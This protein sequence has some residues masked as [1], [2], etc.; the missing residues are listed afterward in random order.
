MRKQSYLASTRI[1]S[2]LGLCADLLDRG[3]FQLSKPTEPERLV[4]LHD[5]AIPG[6]NAV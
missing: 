3:H 4:L 2:A 1:K 5:D 6:F